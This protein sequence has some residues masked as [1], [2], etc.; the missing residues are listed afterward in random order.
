MLKEFFYFMT[1]LLLAGWIY[2]IFTPQG[3]NYAPIRADG[4]IDWTT[5]EEVEDVNRL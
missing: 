5:P 1:C 4:P 3:D 2:Y